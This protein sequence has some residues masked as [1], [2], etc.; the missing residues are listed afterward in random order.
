MPKIAEKLS[1]EIVKH[2]QDASR[3]IFDPSTNA[4]VL[5]PEKDP[6][7]FESVDGVEII[8]YSE[9]DK[10]DPVLKADLSE[11]YINGFEGPP[12]EY[13]ESKFTAGDF[14]NLGCAYLWQKNPDWL[15][16]KTYFATAKGKDKTSNLI[17]EANNKSIEEALKKP[18][19]P[20]IP[21]ILLDSLREIRQKVDKPVEVL[22][23][24][25][26]R[27]LGPFE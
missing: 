23:S 16:A 10:K 9:Q 12:K 7:K 1:D 20:V 15:K 19:K 6:N 22:S 21:V 13:D 5:A 18:S 3:V 8:V 14:N 27:N 26:I 25:E 2:I 24:A 17:I 11:S 4:I